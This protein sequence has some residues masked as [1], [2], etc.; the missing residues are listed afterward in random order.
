MKKFSK[1]LP[2]VLV[3]L[4]AA[5][6]FILMLY[7]SSRESATM[8]ELAHIPAG[9]GYVKYLDYRLNPEHPPLIKAIAALP[10]LF[11]HL[12]FPTDKSSWQTDINGQWEAG[13]QFIYESGNNADGIIQWARLGPMLLTLL[14]IIFIYIWAK[15]LIGRWWA[16][17]PTFLF[18][19]SPTV[20]AHGHYVTTDIGAA[21]GIFIA[22]YYFVKYLL[23][24]SRNNLVLAGLTFGIAQLI[25]FSA[26]LIIPF[27]GF[28]IIVFCLW[29]TK[30]K[31]LGFFGGLGQFF[32]IFF[33]YLLSW[34]IIFVV[35]YI[36][37]YLVYFVSTVNYPIQKQK[38]DTEFTLTSFSGGPDTK[39]ETCK[40][41]SDISFGRRTRCLAEINIWMAGNKIMRPL[42]Q[43]MLGVLMVTQRSSG[44]NTAYF[45]GEVSAAGWWYYFPVVFIL[46]ESLPSLILI[47]LAFVLGLWAIIKNIFKNPRFSS[48]LSQLY[49]YLG[50]HFAEFSMIV[51]VILYWAYSINSPLNIGVRHILPTLPFIYILTASGLKKWLAGKTI[52][53]TNFWKNLFASLANILKLSLKGVLISVL[54]IWYLLETLFTAPYFLSYFNQFGGGTDNGYK[55]VTDSNY[56]W[57]QDL[58]RLVSWVNDNKIDKIVIDYFGGGNPK[59]YLDGKVEYWQSSKGNPSEE[60]I[61]WLAISA[62]TLQSALGRLHPGQQRNPEDE[63]RWLKN[64]YEPYARAGKS[65]FIYKLF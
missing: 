8:D 46:K 43:Y 52:V 64:P 45:L 9:Y 21:L 26:V 11:Q 28:L 22:A 25:K 51:F 6:S 29:K 2:W 34:I 16:L 63:Y 48:L 3:C 54:L 36:L 62:N 33:R 24:P 37:V 42:G 4:M 5:A 53:G 65:I 18:A 59:Y 14:L 57:G 17:L 20:L 19:L 23:W 58:K 61:K 31:W 50:T 47:F 15:E 60:G 56:D 40:L 7:A 55:Y 13:T 39:G 10:L 38:A 12:K 27:F 32:K 1:F 41:N 35:G 44:G 30:N 49:Y